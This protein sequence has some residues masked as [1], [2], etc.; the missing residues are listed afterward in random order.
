MNKVKSNEHIDE[1]PNEVE[2]PVAESNQKTNTKPSAFSVWFDGLSTKDSAAKILPFVFFLALIGM[3]YIANKHKAEKNIRQIEK[4]NKELKEL[5]W[6]YMTAKTE[7][8]FKSKQTEVAKITETF[9][10]K[11]AVV[12]PQKIVVK[13]K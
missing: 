2:T 10:L 4:I 1:I 13:K 11:E 8:M 6:E 5:N 7:L 12:P 3:F 9:G